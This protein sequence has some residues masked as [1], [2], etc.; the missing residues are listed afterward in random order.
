MYPPGRARLGDDSVADWIGNRREDDRDRLGRVHCGRKRRTRSED[1]VYLEPYQFGCEYGKALFSAVSEPVL[2]RNGLPLDVPL[3]T[4]ALAKCLDVLLGR[5]LSS[6]R[7]VADSREPGQLLRAG[8]KRSQREAESENEP[9]RA[10]G[11]SVGITGGE[12]SRRVPASAVMFVKVV[13]CARA[14]L[15]RSNSYLLLSFTSSYGAENG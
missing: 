2:D 12:S 15:I 11:T 4:Q 7:K 5:R 1:K 6:E 13:A 8:G 9:D 14:A 10:H 3:L